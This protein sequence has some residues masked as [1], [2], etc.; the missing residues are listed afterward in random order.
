MRVLVTGS[1]GFIGSATVAALLARGHLVH[2]ADIKARQD[3]ADPATAKSVM[4]FDP[5]VIV[6]L[7]SSCSTAASIRE[8][9]RTFRDTVVTAVNV[10]E[11]ARKSRCQVIV[12]SS[13]KARDGMTPYGASKRMVETWAE[14]YRKCYN[15]PVIINRPGTVYGPGQEGSADSGWIAWFCKAKTEK[16]PVVIN[17]DGTQVRDLLHVSDYAQLLVQQVERFDTYDS[18]EIWDVGGGHDNAV[19]VKQ[20]ADHLGLEYR[21]GEERYGDY[22]TYIGL[23]RVPGWEPKV[24]WWE[25]ETLR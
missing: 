2:G 18:G 3:L 16:K 15:L 19:S 8:P 24:K 7:A 23:N 10:L 1:A 9:Q 13:V 12:T 22:H 25:S 21:F 11:E 20:I 5:H 14:E 4:Y 6:H 17:G